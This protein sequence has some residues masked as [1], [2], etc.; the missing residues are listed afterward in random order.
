MKHA[1]LFHI[2]AV[3]VVAIALPGIAQQPPA[4]KGEEVGTIERKDPRF[5]KLIPKDARIIKVAEGFKW[6]EGPVWVPAKGFL[7][8]SDIPNNVIN[9]YTPGKGVQQFLKPSGYT[10]KKPREG[11]PGSNGLM[12]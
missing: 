2:I 11:E 7:L 12:L 1:T 4:Q 8:F 10:G 9:S 6:T 3:I 5:D